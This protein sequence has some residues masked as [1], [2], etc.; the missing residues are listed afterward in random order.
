MCMKCILSVRDFSFPYYLSR[1]RREEYEKSRHSYEKKSLR[2]FPLCLCIYCKQSKTGAGKARGQDLWPHVALMYSHRLVPNWMVCIAVY[3]CVWVKAGVPRYK[4]NLT[5]LEPPS[6]ATFP[7]TLVVVVWL[8]CWRME[9]NRNSIK[10]EQ[11][12]Q[13]H[14]ED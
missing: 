5:V 1:Q 11:R 14:G 12:S 6:R 4:R 13:L 9:A 7:R 2:P 8:S 3:C 10:T